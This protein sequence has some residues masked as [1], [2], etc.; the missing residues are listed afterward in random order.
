M[1]QVNLQDSHS[2]LAPHHERGREGTCV[3][4]FERQRAVL[5]AREKLSRWLHPVSDLHRYRRI[6]LVDAPDGG[7]EGLFSEDEFDLVSTLEL[8]WYRE[9]CDGA[10]EML[11]HI[12]EQIQVA[13]RARNGEDE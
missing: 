12:S 2:D 10:R 1:T 9:A 7:G 11:D 5:D 8:E 4:S 13:L 6:P 3:E